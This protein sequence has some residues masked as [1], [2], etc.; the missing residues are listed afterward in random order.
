MTSFAP[1]LLSDLPSSLPIF[2][3]SSALLMPKGQLPLN[4]FEPRYLAMVDHALAHDRLIGMMQPRNPDAPM[5]EAQVFSVGCAGRISA[6]SET[7][8]GRY[9]ITLTGVCRFAYQDDI[10]TIGGFRLAQVDFAPYAGDLGDAGLNEDGQTDNRQRLM[11]SLT[12]YF[13]LKGFGADWQK[14][15]QTPTVTLVNSL[16]MI[17]PFNALEKQALLEV[18]ALSERTAMLTSLMDMASQGGGDS[19][20]P[21]PPRSYQ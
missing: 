18:K 17:L 7:D 5:G 16:A 13:S 12:S 19:D 8:D 2:P 11:D 3:L 21:Q 9:H 4:I 10:T 1:K 20:D 15:R 6:Y 14:L